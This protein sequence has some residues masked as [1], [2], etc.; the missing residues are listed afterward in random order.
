MV[1]SSASYKYFSAF[2]A[3]FLWGG[4]AYYI[5]AKAS[6][7]TGVVSGVTQGTASF[8]TTLLAVYVVTKLY[9][10]IQNKVGKVVLPAIAIISGLAMGLTAVHTIAGT[11]HIVVTIAPSLSAGFVFCLLTAYKLRQKEVAIKQNN[12]LHG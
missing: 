5:N 2:T 10:L 8:F 7:A 12:Q 6:I 11:P 4:W 3:L 1:K 9:N